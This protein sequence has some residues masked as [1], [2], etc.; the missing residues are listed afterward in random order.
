MKVYLDM[1]GVLCDF[2]QSVHDSLKIP[3][4]LKTYPY[5]L[6]KWDVLE[7][8]IA[9]HGEKVK[10]SDI[11]KPTDTHEFWD[12]MNWMP[13]GKMILSAVQYCTNKEDL[14]ICTSPMARPGAWSGKIAWLNKNHIHKNIIVMSASKALLAHPDCILIDD[15]D[16]NIEDFI[17]AG[18]RGYLVPR[19][20]NKR[21]LDWKR[22]F[23]YLP[24]LIHE[25]ET[26]TEPGT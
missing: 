5:E 20:W 8:I 26:F 9:V 1:D 17:A 19:P 23:E 6:G 18:G 10:K 22:G 21:H 16:S 11:Y 24:E 15:K 2:V 12:T 4:E 14:Y 3:Y 7:E 13:D 25:L